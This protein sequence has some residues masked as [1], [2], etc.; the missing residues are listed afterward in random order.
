GPDVLP[1]DHT[2]D[3]LVLED[4]ALA[5]LRGLD[6]D[7]H[8]TVLPATARLP[9]EL[10]LDV[11]RSATDRFAIRNL[12]PADVRIDL[13]LATQTVDDDLEGQ[14]AHPGDDRLTG[15]LVRVDPEGRILLGEL[16]ETVG[17]LVLVRLRLRLDRDLD[18][19]L[20]EAHG[21]QNDWIVRIAERIAR[22][23]VL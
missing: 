12:R 7:H 23:R 19:R 11:Q 20:G 2:A 22:L 14:L 10:A 13:E 8:M 1:R 9:D 6:V 17:Q 21:L 3:D 18:H 4:E 16:A 15:P 5:R